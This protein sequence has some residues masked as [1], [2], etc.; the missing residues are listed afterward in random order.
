MCNFNNKNDPIDNIT[1]CIANLNIYPSDMLNTH[2]IMMHEYNVE[3]KENID[4]DYDAIVVAVN[5]DKYMAL[6]E[7]YFKSNSDCLLRI[8]NFSNVYKFNSA[9]CYMNDLFS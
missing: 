2:K 8:I 3:L 4:N 6:D 5:H 9:K 1:E 7:Q